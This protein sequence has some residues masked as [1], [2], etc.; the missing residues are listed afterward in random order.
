MTSKHGTVHPRW[1]GEQLL[2]RQAET[3][4][5][6]SSPLARGT[7]DGVAQAVMTRR[8]IPAGA[9]NRFEDQIEYGAVTVHPRWRGEQRFQDA[10]VLQLDWFI[11]A[12]AG[13]RPPARQA[14]RKTPVHPRW[15]G[16]QTT[17]VIAAT[18]L[19]GSSPLARGTGEQNAGRD[20]GGRFIPA[21][22]G[23]R[24]GD[25]C[26]LAM[27]AVHPRWRGEQFFTGSP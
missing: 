22:A 14:P 1:R 10:G 26:G 3:T 7:A 18:D 4:L 9:G 19:T 27:G 17:S 25:G 11:P 2:R 24:L 8:F 6:G 5:L 23:N 21:G 15:R 13:N 20:S 16:E 12:G